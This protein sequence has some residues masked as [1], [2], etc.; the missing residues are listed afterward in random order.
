MRFKLRAVTLVS[1]VPDVG[2]YR[3]RV[4]QAEV[5]AE[6]PRS[7]QVRTAEVQLAAVAELHRSFDP[8]F[9][10]YRL[11][12]TARQSTTEPRLP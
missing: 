10:A 8:A 4:L 11:E 1:A 5:S 2:K 9:R 3:R 12:P 7:L 6:V